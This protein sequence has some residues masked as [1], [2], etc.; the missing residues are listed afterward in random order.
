MC[1]FIIGRLS[2]V[3]AQGRGGIVDG[4]SVLR[5]QEHGSDPDVTPLLEHWGTDTSGPVSGAV[6]F[7]PESPFV[8]EATVAVA[9]VGGHDPTAGKLTGMVCRSWQ[10]FRERYMSFTSGLT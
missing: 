4:G 7:S 9:G 2:S 3:G 5:G 1:F 10:Q 6:V 8:A